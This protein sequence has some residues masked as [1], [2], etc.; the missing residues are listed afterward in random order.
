MGETPSPHSDSSHGGCFT[1]Y[2][3]PSTAQP[4]VDKPSSCLPKL[5]LTVAEATACQIGE[6]S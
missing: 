3:A 4:D 6:I 2:I 1:P 5:W